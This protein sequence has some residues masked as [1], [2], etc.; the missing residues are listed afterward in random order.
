MKVSINWIKD[1]VDLDGVDI[2]KLI[3]RFTMGVAEVEGVEYHGRNISGV[4][5]AKILSVENVPTSK[6][7]HLL[8]V[9]AGNETLQIVCGAPNVR[10]GLVTALAKIDAKLGD[11][12][13]SKATLAGV[14]SFGMCCGYDEI[15]ISDDHSGIVELDDDTPIGVDIKKVLNIEDIVFEIDN[16][17]LTNRPD[18][19][20]HYGIA[21]EIAVLTGRK[22][23][24]LAVQ[25]SNDFEALSPVNVKVSSKECNRYTSAKMTNVTVKKANLNMQIRLF[26]CGMR[27]INLLADV[28]N[29]V[30]LELGQPMHAFD[31]DYV[32]KIEV[33]NLENDLKFK[34]LDSVERQL[35]KGNMV[36]STN[37]EVVALAGIMGG[38]NSEITPETTSVLIE[39]A[40][41]DSFKVRT[42]ATSLGMRTEAS[43][44]YEKSLDPE[45][46]M[47]ALLRLVYLVKQRDKNA[48]IASSICDIYN[49][50][51]PKLEIEITKP[52]IDS[53]VGKIIK[54]ETVL[55]ILQGLEFK[56]LSNKNGVYKFGV[57]TFRAT[58]DINGKAD[59]VE[60]IT[61]IY[62]YDNIEP[63]SI[64]QVVKPTILDREIAMEYDAKFALADRFS[65]NETHSYI[66]YDL[67][68]NKALGLEPNSVI[69][70]INSI[71]KDN[72]KI[73]STMVP[74]LMKVI[75]DNKNSFDSFGTFEMGRVV[76]N[77][78]KDGLADETKSFCVLTFKRAGQ[79]EN[80]LL[81]VKEMI[82]YLFEYIFKMNYSLKLSSP[83]V[84]YYH[85]KNYYEISS[86][87][88]T[89]GDIFAIHPRNADLVEE[90]CAIVGFELNFSKLS[91]LPQHKIEFAKISK[92][93][94]TKLDFN[95][96]IPK[97]KLYKDI[98][99]YAQSVE[100]KLNFTVSLLDIYANADGTKSYTLHYEV[101]SLERNLTADDIEV[102]HSAVIK[103]FKENGIELKI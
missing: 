74:S 4:V 57:P 9:D 42:T 66:W 8:K 68:S 63:L 84:A 97:N 29:Y 45:L 55:K 60:E 81:K 101:N 89:L 64:K 96:V 75:F 32:Q 90:N 3:S 65:L 43:A 13:I 20:G 24:P 52:Y 82:D 12:T 21:R 100:T 93:P 56:L 58:K 62:G 51:Y 31:G 38:E 59:L 37:G 53:F 47:Q 18:L 23:K 87:N 92:F 17:S 27:S 76:K 33:F 98:I 26:Y 95:F 94:T 39:S 86:D 102:F 30:M 50:K 61:R 79:V 88:I 15:G 72:D 35:K 6:K 71:N 70:C 80:E 99:N 48:K 11:I 14:E 34:T 73:R 103:K 2:E 54:E 5:T 19:W 44:R 41:F 28:T 67:A 10:V 25:N 49:K 69:R 36:T 40:N 7:L 22:L 91:K 83:N 46:T 78:Q 85:P 16:K 77:L 1:F